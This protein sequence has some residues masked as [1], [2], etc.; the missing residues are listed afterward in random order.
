MFELN[1]SNDSVT[2]STYGFSEADIPD[3]L[4]HWSLEDFTELLPDTQ[5]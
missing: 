4:E 3:Q 5:K 1:E 2:S